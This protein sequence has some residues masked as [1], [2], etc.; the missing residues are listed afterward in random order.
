[1]KPNQTQ[2]TTGESEKKTRDLPNVT[3]CHSCGSRVGGDNNNKKL[4]ILY[5]EWRIVLLCTKCY[6]LIESS[7]VCSYC[8]KQ[9]SGSSNKNFHCR[10]CN[11]VVHK[12]C[13]SKRKTVAPWSYSCNYDNGFSVCVDCWV[14]KSVAIKREVFRFTRRK[15]PRV[16]GNWDGCRENS[17]E[18]VVKDAKCVAQVKVEAAVRAR[19][20]A[21]K[22]ALE[23]RKAAELAKNASNLVADIDDDDDGGGAKQ[24][25]NV[26]DSNF[27]FELH[28]AMN[29]SLQISNNLCLVNTSCWAVPRIGESNGRKLDICPSKGGDKECWKSKGIDDGWVRPDAK[30]DEN[31][32]AQLTERKGSS[33][34]KLINS[35]RD[36]NRAYPGSQSFREGNESMAPED[37]SRKRKHESCLFKYSRKKI[38]LKYSR[39]KLDERLTPDGRPKFLYEGF[40]YKIQAS[41]AERLLGCEKESF[42]T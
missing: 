19:E 12:S 26:D 25:T 32:G 35:R 9:S 39:R 23:A 11:R 29:S 15:S 33:S 17:L 34:N 22:K 24:F 42:G 40:F 13:F 20:L 38:L 41:A 6:T 4:E 31:A 5:S 18:D 2:P 1:M 30:K 21:V 7:K 8:F 27:A 36:D 37:E 28:R 16:L 3:E 14:P 10:K